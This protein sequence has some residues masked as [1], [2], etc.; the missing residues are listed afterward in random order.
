MTHD[1]A[2]GDELPLTQEFLSVMLGVRRAGVTVAAH[3]LQ[4]AGLIRYRRGLITI[5]DRP[6]LEDAACECYG[7]VRQQFEQMLGTGG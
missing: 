4:E 7:I 5:L 1:R 2:D 3:T 6:A